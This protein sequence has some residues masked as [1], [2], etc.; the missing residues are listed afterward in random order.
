MS[1]H[2]DELIK[3]SEGELTTRRAAEL[4]AELKASPQLQAEQREVDHLIEALSQPAPGLDEVDLRE[5]LWTRPVPERRSRTQ[6]TRFALAATALAA[7]ALAVFALPGLHDDEFRAKGASGSLSGFD[8]F[9]V[10]NGIAEPLGPTIHRGEPLGFAYRNQPDSP[11]HALA[12]FAVD[13]TGRFFWFYPEWR[14]GQAPPSSI[15]IATSP[16]RIELPDAVKHDFA[17]GRLLIYA[18]FTPEPVS[19]LDV[20]AGRTATPPQGLAVEVLP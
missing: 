13:A 10:R 2:F 4:D 1:T 7:M 8:A 18:L 16:T 20:E 17:S 5:G 15:S 11:N 6:R 19:V 14:E 9:V 12:I 3:K